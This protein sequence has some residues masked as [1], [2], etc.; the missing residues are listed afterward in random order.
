MNRP[1]TLVNSCMGSLV[2]KS[3]AFTYFLE[4]TSNSIESNHN[5][6]SS[7]SRLLTDSAPSNIVWEIAFVVINSIKD[8]SKWP[9]SSIFKKVLKCEPSST[10]SNTPTPVV[11]ERWPIRIR[12]ALNHLGP[13]FVRW[14]WRSRMSMF[15]VC[16]CYLPS[17]LNTFC[18][19][20]VMALCLAAAF[21]Y[22]PNVCRDYDLT[23]LSGGC[24]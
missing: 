14:R 22:W 24:Q 7:V 2:R 4:A 1:S 13:S 23:H 16:Y 10:D 17:V 9:R 3:E 15:S 18:R 5:V 11:F 19:H 8:F 21:G 12:T 6:A 20:N